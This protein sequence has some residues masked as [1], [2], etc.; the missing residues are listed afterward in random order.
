M[1]L[2]NRFLDALINGDLGNGITIS[3]QEFMQYFSDD[4]ES[5]TGCFL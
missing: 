3:R 4:H 5:F 2:K 1:S